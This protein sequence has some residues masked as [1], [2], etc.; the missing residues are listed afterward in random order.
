MN[1]FGPGTRFDLADIME[2]RQKLPIQDVVLNAGTDITV[3]ETNPGSWTITSTA[4]GGG[5]ASGATVLTQ[6]DFGATETGYAS[7]SV[8]APTMVGGEFILVSPYA[9]A[10][11][12]HDP[13]DYAVEGVTAYP[14]AAVAGVGFDII[15][16][17]PN[18]TWGK[19]AIYAFYI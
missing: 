4:S 1:Y 11:T 3:R 7:V 8:A 18:G 13:D 5:G 6:V 12:D 14:T 17:A 16:S 19:Y 10:T 2:L 15:A 9:A